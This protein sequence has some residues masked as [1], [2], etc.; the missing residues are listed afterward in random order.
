[1]AAGITPTGKSDIRGNRYL[2]PV[3]SDPAGGVEGNLNFQGISCSAWHGYII[4]YLFGSPNEN[5][6]DFL[7]PVLESNTYDE[8]A[9]LPIEDRRV[10]FREKGETVGGRAEQS[11]AIPTVPLIGGNSGPTGW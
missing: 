9:A 4:G 6:E 7:R 2:G 3:S 11:F 8:N 10:A 5:N 1:M